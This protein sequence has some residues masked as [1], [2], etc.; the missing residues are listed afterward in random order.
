MDKCPYKNIAGEVGK[1]WHAY[2][3]LGF[4]VVDTVGT[5]FLF[6]VPSAWFF[7]GNVWIHFLAWLVIGEIAH[8]AFGSQTA[9]LTAL[10]IDV[11][12]DS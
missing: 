9:G 2:R 12:C 11:Q 5:F 7:K 4:S 6:A 1:G 10:G 3:F 8:Y